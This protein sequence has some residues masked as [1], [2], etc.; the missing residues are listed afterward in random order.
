MT[1]LP[2]ED[3]LARLAANVVAPTEDGGQPAKLVALMPCEPA[4]GEV[5]V[6][7]WNDSA[8]E[9]LVELLR[10]DTGERISDDIALRESLVLLAMVETV[11]ELASF[12][13][14]AKL[15]TGL[16]AWSGHGTPL[17]ADYAPVRARALAALDALAGLSSGDAP[18]VARTQLLDAY[19]AALRELEHAWEAL[20]QQAELWSDAHL[21]AHPGDAE[22]LGQVQELW[23]LL[24]EA[25]MGPL[26]R[27]AAAALHDAREAGVAMAADV[28]SSA[29]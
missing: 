19:G 14:L 4:I 3:H 26:S 13:V 12:D 6:A 28:A 15:A 1:D 2:L 5:A 10:L 16:A 29:S 21:G 7:V 22:A 8:G 18:R 17:P 11:E 9:G 27:T 24:G 23:Q 20:E 25:R